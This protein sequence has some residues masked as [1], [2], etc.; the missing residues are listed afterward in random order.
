MRAFR[1]GLDVTGHNIANINTRGYSRR[2]LDLAELGPTIPGGPGRGVEVMGIRAARDN[3]VNARIGRESAGLAKDSSILDGVGLVDAAIGLPGSSIDARLTA[4]F[5][6]WSGLATDVTSTP[7]RDAVAREAQALEQAIGELSNGFAAQ[8]RAADVGIRDGVAELN[9]LSQQV[10]A[11]NGH[12]TAGGPDGDSLRDQRDLMI[13]RMSALADVAVV[14]H[15]NGMAD[16]SLAGGRAIVVGATGYAVQ[17]QAVPPSGHATLQLHGVDVTGSLT[18]GHLGGLIELRDSVLPQYQTRL[19]QL[20]FDL[21][22]E[23][24]AVHAAGFDANGAAGGNFF[25]PLTSVAGA[26][27]ALAVDSAIVADSQRI[28]GSS[29][30]AVGDNQAARA[31]AALRDA[32]VMSGGTTTPAGAWAALVYEVGSDVS[33]ARTAS[34]TREQVMRQLQQLRDQA[35]GV[36]LDEEAANLMRYQRSYEASARYFTTVV[37][38]LD[39]LM[40]MVR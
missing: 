19:D 38:T 17:V 25:A 12:I 10:A 3:Y 16:V 24:N 33:A 14:H 27:Q 36:S 32:S 18:N 6:A 11:L 37:D 40:G 1:T 34:G 20:A 23:V 31:M 39:T 35:A 2:T 4:F 29:T 9:E 26:A 22:R 21:A 8:Q 5:D 28:A 7:A 13:E 30:G 15:T